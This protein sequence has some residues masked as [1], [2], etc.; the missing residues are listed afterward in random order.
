MP[1]HRHGAPFGRRGGPPW[2]RHSHWRRRGLRR[3]LTLAFAAVALAAVA[4]TV[5][6]TLGAVFSAQSELFELGSSDLPVPDATEDRRGP[7]WWGPFDG[8]RDGWWDSPDAAVA[9]R[10]FASVSRTAFL[11]AFLAFL[12]AGVAA[13]IVTRLFTRPLVTLTSAAE[14]LGA[15]ERGI[16]VPQTGGDDELTRL[17]R[18]FNHLVAQLERQEEWRR[19]MVADVAHDLRT[20]LS[21][22]RSEIEALQDGVRPV[23]PE[24]LQMLHGEVMLLARLVADL[25]TLS[26]T[27]S[28][29]IELDRAEVPIFG[30]LRDVA[31]YFEPRA[32]GAGTSVVVAGV[33]PEEVKGISFDATCS[34]VVRDR[35]G[36]P[37]PGGVP[38]VF[39]EPVADLQPQRDPDRLATGAPRVQP[40]RVGGVMWAQGEPFGVDREPQDPVAFVF[41]ADP[42]FKGRVGAGGRIGQAGSNSPAERIEILWAG[43]ESHAGHWQPRRPRARNLARPRR[44][45]PLVRRSRR[46]GRSGR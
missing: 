31:D 26:L 43:D 45:G 19:D 13:A 36:A 34:L 12:M 11:A 44:R 35:A 24:S 14:R 17:S 33:R 16:R 29:A 8:E 1:S 23:S 5:W 41:V 46:D 6:L 15:G 39:L 27:E 25:R 2:R 18:A 22:M 37:L 40:A 9:R 10:A 21:V 4:L 32:R 30:F 38:G 42:A 7:P 20:P 3:K 28:A